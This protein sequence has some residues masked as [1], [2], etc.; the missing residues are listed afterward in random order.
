[1]ARPGKRDVARTPALK[2]LGVRIPVDL[3]DRFHHTV[4][5]QK[6][7]ARAVIQEFVEEYLAT[8]EKKKRGA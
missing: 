5:D 4:Y 3:A 2:N 8:H 1:M 7:S 6:T